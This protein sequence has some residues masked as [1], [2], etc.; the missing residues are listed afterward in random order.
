MILNRIHPFIDLLVCPNLNGFR[1]GFHLITNT[2]N[3]EDNRRHQRK[4]S[5]SNDDFH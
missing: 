1:K 3:S 2:N 4:E 5:T